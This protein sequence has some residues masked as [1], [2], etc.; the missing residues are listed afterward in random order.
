MMPAQ[1]GIRKMG[2]E[3]HA[4]GESETA[5]AA[6]HNRTGGFVE[7]ERVRLYRQ[8]LDDPSDLR[9]HEYATRITTGG[10]AFREACGLRATQPIGHMPEFNEFLR[11]FGANGIPF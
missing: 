8:T 4:S 6:R 7:T 3:Q 5:V 1:S 10:H 2:Y 11:T 9:W